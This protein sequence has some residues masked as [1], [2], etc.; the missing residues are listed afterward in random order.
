MIEAE[1]GDDPV[2]PGVEGTFKTEAAQILVGLEEGF[3]INGLGIGL[4]SRQMQRQPQNRLIVMTH[5]YLEG[6]AVSLLR[7]A[8]QTRVVNAVG[9]ASD[10]I[11]VRCPGRLSG[12]LPQ[13]LQ[14]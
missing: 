8:D 14:E 6:S 10:G 13:G 3:L 5:Q 9:A 11:G 7:L 2:D 12:S 4:R 1:V